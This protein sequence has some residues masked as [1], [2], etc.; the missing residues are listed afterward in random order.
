VT[1]DPGVVTSSLGVDTAVAAAVAPRGDA[2]QVMLVGLAWFGR[3]AGVWA[4]RV[5]LASVLALADLTGAHLKVGIDRR[6]KASHA[7]SVSQV[8]HVDLHLIT[9]DATAREE[10][11]P[12]S[13]VTESALPVLATV[14]D[15][16][17]NDV[18]V[19]DREW[20]GESHQSNVV[21]QGGRAVLR[22][23]DDTGDSHGL[24]PRLHVE[25]IV[26]TTIEQVDSWVGVTEWAVSSRDVEVFVDD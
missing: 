25:T 12:T 9:R 8:Q 13:C 3:W 18:V 23:H 7:T 14:W 2:D 16:H 4:A 15:A 20:S 21:S 26:N 17:W 5:A 10:S 22:V 11:T 1:S 6:A 24:S 19:V